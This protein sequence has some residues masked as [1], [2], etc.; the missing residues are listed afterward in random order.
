[1]N[2]LSTEKRAMALNL[3]VEGSSMSSVS[4][5]LHIDINTVVKLLIDAGQAAIEY[6]DETVQNVDASYIQCDETW[7]T[8]TPSSGTSSTPEE[9]STT[10]VQPGRG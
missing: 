9:L 3:L 1:M 7:L 5:L 6:H 10:Q 4:R 8:S 2:R